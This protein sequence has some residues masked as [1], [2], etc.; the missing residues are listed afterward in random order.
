MR[1]TR[2]FKLLCAVLYAEGGRQAGH[3]GGG[4]CGDALQ[5]G[6]HAAAVVT[7]CTITRHPQRA[8]LAFSACAVFSALAQAALNLAALPPAAG[9]AALAASVRP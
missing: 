4:V 7:T 3:G 6:A 8:L 2:T 9:R 1:L 5:L